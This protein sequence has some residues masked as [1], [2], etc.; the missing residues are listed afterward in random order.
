MSANVT[1]PLTPNEEILEQNKRLKEFHSRHLDDLMN[2]MQ[3][4]Y[5]LPKCPTYQITGKESASPRGRIALMKGIAQGVLPLDKEFTH[6]MYLCLGCRACESACPAG[7]PYGNLIES[8]RNV[9]E[10]TKRDNHEATMIRKVLFNN[11]FNENAKVQSIGKMLYYAQA[12]GLQ[13]FADK[14]GLVHILPKPMANMQK[15]VEKVVSPK[16][17]K[18]RP[19]VIV[20]DVPA[21]KRIGL[22]TGCIMDVMFFDINQATA[23]VL[24]KV[25]FEVIFVEQQQCCGAL[26]AHAGEREGA[27]DVAK[28]NIEAFE[29]EQVDLIVNNAGGCGA[30]LKEYAHW[31]KGDPQWYERAKAFVA[32]IR[33]VN[34]L[35]VELDLLSN[36][37]LKA[38]HATVTYQDSCHL[39]HGQHIREQPRKVIQAIPEV[40]YIELKNA[41]SCCG[42]AGIYNIT[43]FE[44][45]MIILDKKME[46]VK[47]TNAYYIVTS[48]PGCLVQM[49]QGI[50]RAGSQ[51]TMKAVHIMELLNQV[52]E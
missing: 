19:K 30:A 28:R 10:G 21:Q 47:A 40:T 12:L 41:D 48:N 25:G 18:T 13:K 11:V 14:T 9:I 38:L 36:L 15:A 42:S 26:H 27:L 35:L 39:A 43:N 16:I 49:K 37:K 31:F 22:F 20:P 1:R 51:E 17:R 50:I 3:C 34:E 5:C 45:S 7:V 46:D 6:N 29:K 52:M 23:N 24:Q 8:A 33:D 4:G 32:K 44:M 2:C